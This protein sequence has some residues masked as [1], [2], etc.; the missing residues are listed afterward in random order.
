MQQGDSSRK[1]Q[2]I[3][4]VHTAGSW[5]EALVVRGLLESAGIASPALGDGDPSSLPDVMP[6]LHGIEIYALESEAE[7]AR[8][9]IAEYLREAEQGGEDAGEEA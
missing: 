2:R 6:F 3:V 7:G 5:T 1:G 9:L 4:V 8:K